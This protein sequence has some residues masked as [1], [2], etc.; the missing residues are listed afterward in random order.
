MSVDAEILLSL[1]CIR[2]T[3]IGTRF[4]PIEKIITSMMDAFLQAC[5]VHPALELEVEAAGSVPA[6]RYCLRQPFAIIGRHPAADLYLDADGMRPRHV[7]LQA[8]E[9]RIAC[10]N[11]SQTASFSFQEKEIESFSWLTAGQ[12]VQ[13]GSKRVKLLPFESIVDLK[14]PLTDPLAPGSALDI[15]APKITLELSNEEAPGTLKTWPIDR[16][17][18]LIG[19]TERCVIQLNHELISNVH[20]S[21]VL[22]TS[23]LWVVDLLGRG[24]ILINEQPVRVGFLGMEDELHLGPYRLRLQE[25]PAPLFIPRDE[26]EYRP[27]TPAS[28]FDL[29]VSAQPDSAPHVRT[30]HT[31]WPEDH[32]QAQVLEEVM[33]QFQNMQ[34]PMF[35][36][37]Q[38]ILSRMIESFS[39]LQ[40]EQREAV[41]NELDRLRSIAKEVESIQQGKKPA[42]AEEQ[43][44]VPESPAIPPEMDVSRMPP[45]N[46]LQPAETPETAPSSPPLR[47]ASTLLKNSDTSVFRI[48]TKIGN[49][50]DD[51]TPNE[52][53]PVSD[54]LLHTWSESETELLSSDLASE[55]RKLT[56]KPHPQAEGITYGY[57]PNQHEAAHPNSSEYRP[58]VAPH[59][60]PGHP[61][62]DQE[63]A[64]HL[65]LHDRVEVLQ[66]EQSSIWQKL[67]NFFFGKSS[68]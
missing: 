26:S 13:L 49:L 1:S 31:P 46:E 64:A 61:P 56:A 16:L 3:F 47:S 17:L 48:P 36:Q 37:N 22:T 67:S 39:Q 57:D 32:E 66:A 59:P 15:Y 60:D 40:V 23:G 10:I 6:V 68:W 18:T 51:R 11:V 19:R 7:Y 12:S 8:I 58:F 62:T 20:C 14:H 45:V 54:D 30:Y 28:E 35:A 33:D 42:E 9:G 53:A 4:V 65:W 29:T 21:L 44:L 41:K 63:K 50:F 34:G 5:G 43:G 25:K 27:L 2:D 55:A 24:G 38:H 52:P